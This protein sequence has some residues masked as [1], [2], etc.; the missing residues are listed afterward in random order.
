MNKNLITLIVSFLIILLVGFIDKSTSYDTSNFGG[1]V[2]FYPQHQ[3]V[4][5]LWAC[6]CNIRSYT[7]KRG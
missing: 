4:E 7:R 5:T 3:G 2:V 1:T 6:K